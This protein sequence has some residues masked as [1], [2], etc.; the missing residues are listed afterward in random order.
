MFFLRERTNAHQGY[1]KN[2]QNKNALSTRAFLSMIV[3]TLYFRRIIFLVLT[4]SVAPRLPEAP[5]TTMR[6]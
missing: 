6:T 5:V 3:A 2:P 1:E 4:A